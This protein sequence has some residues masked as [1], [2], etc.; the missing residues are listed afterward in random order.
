MITGGAAVN[1]PIATTLRSSPATVQA[2]TGTGFARSLIPLQTLL[3]RTDRIYLLWDGPQ[4]DGLRA[5]A[6]FWAS[7]WLYP[8]PV[9]VG[10]TTQLI[11]PARFDTVLQ[12]TVGSAPARPELGQVELIQTL[13][14]P[15]GFAVAVYRLS[16]PKA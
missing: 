4:D 6:Y 5:Y 10:S 8:R 15:D 7:Y 13:R 1:E 3:P 12:V 9:T 14:Y 2:Q 11:D 16:R